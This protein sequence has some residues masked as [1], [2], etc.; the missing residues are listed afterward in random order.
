MRHTLPAGHPGSVLQRR[1]RRDLRQHLRAHRRRLRVRRPQEVRRPHPPGAAAR[2]RRRQGRAHRRAGREGLRRALQHQARDARGRS[3]RR[4]VD[5]LASQNAVAPAGSF[6]TAHRQDLPAARAATS[7]RSRRFARPR[8]ARTAGSSASATSPECQR[9]FADPP[10]PACASWAATR[11]ASAS[12][13]RRAATSSRSGRNLDAD[14]RAHAQ[15]SCRWAWNSGSVTSQPEAVQA[16]GRRV[17]A[18][19]GGSGGASCCGELR[20]RSACA[21]GWWSRCR[22]RWCWP[23][24]SS[25]CSSSAS[26]CTRFPS[27]R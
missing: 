10:Q 24:P 11:S 9:G 3:C 16:L 1:V 6:E 13:W 25:S 27:A 19:A 17:R 26:A 8:S 18:L 5:A 23:R 14:G 2:A 7:T 22:S 12:R 20:S 4:C 15:R 21:P